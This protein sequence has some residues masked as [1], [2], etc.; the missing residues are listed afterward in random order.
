ME[1]SGYFNSNVIEKS[2]MKVI[3]DFVE[4]LNEMENKIFAY[5]RISTNHKTQKVDRQ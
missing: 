1:K 4:V 2:Y 3:M 5:M